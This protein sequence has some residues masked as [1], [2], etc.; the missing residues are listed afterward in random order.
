MPEWLGPVVAAL[1]TATA[2]LA[3]QR[4]NNLREDRRREE[5]A[6]EREKDRANQLQ[7]LMTQLNHESMEARQQREQERIK[8]IKSNLHGSRVEAHADLLGLINASVEQ[9]TPIMQR[10]QEQDYSAVEPLVPEIDLPLFFLDWDAMQ[11][12]LMKVQIVAGEESANYARMTVDMLKQITLNFPLG[13]QGELS[14]RDLIDN[15]IDL[16]RQ[17]TEYERWL[18]RELGSDY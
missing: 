11:H 9:L 7:L 17:K 3:Q 13:H 8:S 6:H 15:E 1:I 4:L 16:A 5:D 2:L 10:V 14:C 12:A 18:R